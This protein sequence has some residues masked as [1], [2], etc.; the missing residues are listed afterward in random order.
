MVLASVASSQWT[1]RMFRQ[2]KITPCFPVFLLSK[3]YFDGL[4]IV[5][6]AVMEGWFVGLQSAQREINHKLA[7]SLCFKFL[8]EGAFTLYDPVFIQDNK[9]NINCKNVSECKYFLKFLT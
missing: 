5:T 2:V 9:L 1:A 4:K 3:L 7:F 6:C 8:T